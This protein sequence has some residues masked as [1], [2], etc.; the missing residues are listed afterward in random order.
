[1]SKKWECSL[2]VRTPFD[3]VQSWFK[4]KPE[5]FK[6]SPDMFQDIAFGKKVQRSKT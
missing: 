6:I 5:I 3:A 4:T 1:L 2:K